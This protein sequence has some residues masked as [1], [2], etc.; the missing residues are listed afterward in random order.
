[1]NG[2]YFSHNFSKKIKRRVDE[3][4]GSTHLYRKLKSLT[5][6][7]ANEIIKKYRIKKTSLLLKN[8]EG[9]V[10]E[11]MY[12]V[13]FSN[14]SYFSKCFKTEFGLSPKEYLQKE[15]KHSYDIQG[16][17]GSVN[18]CFQN[19]HLIFDK[20]LYMK[21]PDSAR[22]LVCDSISTVVVLTKEEL[23]FFT[24][25]LQFKSLKRKE[26]ILREGEMCDFAAFIVK[27]SL[28][29][30]YSIEGNEHT[31]QF[32]FEK[33][34]YTDYESFL[35]G[36]PSQQNIETLEKTEILVLEKKH[37]EEVYNRYP[38]FERFGRLMAERAY[39]GVRRKNEALTNQSAED[40]YL[41]LLKERPK[42]V[43]RVPQHYIASYLGIQPQSLSRIRKKIQKDS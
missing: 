37:L 8:K 35:S 20:L 21:I 13:C 40:R 10:S 42:V 38:K 15:S 39:L 3:G 19:Y 29:Y 43:E 16:N 22:Q 17:I 31:G 1:M 6:I 27:G 41:N 12:E 25:L 18:S 34:W 33:S 7:S 4:M 14:L 2:Y 23:E 36:K 30:F 9:N 32:F 28:R 11:I 5:H 24:S 26:L